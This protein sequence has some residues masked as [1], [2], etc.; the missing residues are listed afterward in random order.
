MPCVAH[1]FCLEIQ[2][3]E[4]FNGFL[5]F[6]VVCRD[7]Q[8]F[9]PGSSSSISGDFCVPARPWRGTGTRRSP[10]LVQ[11]ST[12]FDNIYISYR[13]VPRHARVFW[14]C[15]RG[16]KECRRIWNLLKISFWKKKCLRGQESKNAVATNNAVTV[17]CG[18]GPRMPSLT[19]LALLAGGCELKV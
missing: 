13:T 2:N 17:S 9:R 19:A 1:G 8:G 12:F 14:E 3:A 4:T 5:F 10:P 16:K 15:L 6:G 11:Q 7:F 18:S